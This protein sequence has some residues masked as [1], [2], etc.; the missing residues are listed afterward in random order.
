[1]NW[2]PVDHTVLANE[3]VIDGR[4]WRSGALVEQREL[5]QWFFKITD[6][7]E[8]L[9]TGLDTLERW[10]DKVLLMQR[11]WIGRSEGLLLRFAL[12]A[13][14]DDA[15]EIEVFTTRADTLFGAKFVA[16]AAD[17]PLAQSIAAGNPA[18]KAFI[19]ECPMAPDGHVGRG[20][21]NGGEKG[22]RHR[23]QGRSPL[24]RHMAAAGLCRQF[25]VDGLRDR[26][27][28]RLPGA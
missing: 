9:L 7:A 25:R 15:R 22:L 1:M 19:D 2:D 24:R 5:T 26:R 16:V 20:D 11:N 4:G 27:D 10:P 12:A 6:Y 23:P 28:F 3:Q 13:P 21:R 14:S 8:E 17:H 18:L